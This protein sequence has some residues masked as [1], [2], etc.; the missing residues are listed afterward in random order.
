MIYALIYILI[1]FGIAFWGLQRSWKSGNLRSEPL[2]V[3]AIGLTG[4]AVLWPL[5]AFIGFAQK[6]GKKQ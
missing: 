3:H 5:V 1:G 4:V 6:Y 2:W